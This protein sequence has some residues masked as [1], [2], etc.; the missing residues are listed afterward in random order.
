MPVTGQTEYARPGWLGMALALSTG[1]V[2]TVGR[3]LVAQTTPSENVLLGVALATFSGLAWALSRYFIKW[4]RL[5]GWAILPTACLLALWGIE[6]ANLEL[7]WLAGALVLTLYGWLVA[8]PLPRL[9]FYPSAA[10]LAGALT[11]ALIMIEQIGAQFAAEELFLLMEWSGL[12][13]ITVVLIV[14]AHLAWPS[15]QSPSPAGWRAA[16]LLIPCLAS[17]AVGMWTYPTSFSPTQPVPLYSGIT[18]ST[19]WLCQTVP[20]VPVSQTLTSTQV[21]ARWLTRITENPRAGVPEWGALALG[22]ASETWA[23]RFREALLTEAAQ[24]R[25]T[26]PANSVKYGQYLA[27]LRLYYY[28]AVRTAFPSVFSVDDQVQV[29]NWF[30]NIN[31]RAMTVEWSDLA[32]SWAFQVPPRGPYENQENGATLL[33]LLNRYGLNA[34]ELAEANVAYLHGRSWGWTG[35]FRNS[36]DAVA[37]Q[38]EWLNNAYLQM[39]EPVN[40]AA[41]PNLKLAFEWLLAQSLPGG[42]ALSYNHLPSRSWAGIWLLGAHL[43]GDGRYL[44]QA[45][46]A[47]ASVEPVFAQPGVE[48][49]GAITTRL[50]DLGSCLIYGDSGIPTRV[51]PLAPDKIVFRD[52]WSAEAA[53][54]LL[55][56]RFTGW[57]RYRATNTLTLLYQKKPVAADNMLGSVPDWMPAGRILF[58]DKR[59]PRENLNGLVIPRT[60]LSAVLFQFTG[61]GGPWAQDPPFVAEVKQITAESAFTHSETSM[62]WNKW[63]HQ[64]QVWFYHD[65]GPMIIIDVAQGPANHAAVTWNLPTATLVHQQPLLA[66]LALGVDSQFTE[67][68]LLSDMSLSIGLTASA[69]TAGLNVTTQST[70][71]GIVRLVTVFLPVSWQLDAEPLQIRDKQVYLLLYNQQTHLSIPLWTTP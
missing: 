57:H 25:F 42:A 21:Y 63:H 70:Q 50:P 71:P 38:L 10:V 65:G 7:T 54:A 46:Q 47:L 61:L 27:T 59:I 53:Y 12:T 58:R 39:G 64:R 37:Y 34:P 43:T 1:L 60:G 11:A 55:N 22:H 35:R 45:E 30:A 18:P 31:R 17:L 28:Q 6:M 9:A 56:L 13:G 4:T 48:R 49:L 8:A 41:Q 32:Y 67:L 26:E 24:Q 40:S 5:N 33:T 20:A 14:V 66:K 16:A 23:A 62:T 29:A 15:A 2:W 44:W 69:T 19:P 51:G 68:Y 52:G 3:A 36:D